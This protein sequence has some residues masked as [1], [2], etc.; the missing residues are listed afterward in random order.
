[1]PKL[2]FTDTDQEIELPE[3][4]S[5]VEPCEEAGVPFACT[6]GVCGTCVIRVRR[7]E[8]DNLSEPTEAELDFFGS[9][10][11]ERLACQCCLMKGTVHVKF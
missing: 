5:L 8:M 3:G 1:M 7:D 4:A 11:D 9:I 10:D 2:V 6:E